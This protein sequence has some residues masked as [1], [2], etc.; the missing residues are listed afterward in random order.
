MVYGSVYVGRKIIVFFFMFMYIISIYNDCFLF[1]VN[2]VVIWR[3]NDEII[4]D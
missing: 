2:V 1:L 3:L 4:I